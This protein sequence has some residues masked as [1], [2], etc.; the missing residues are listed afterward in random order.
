VQHQKEATTG[1]EIATATRRMVEGVQRTAYEHGM[2]IDPQTGTYFTDCS[3]FVSY[4][5]ESIAPEHY[6][7]IPRE[8][9]H[10][11]PR[12]FEF[13]DYFVSR[14]A[15]PS[16]GWRRVEQ[17]C[18]ARAGDLIAWR[19]AHVEED[20]DSGHVLVIA[21]A[22]IH[23]LGDV[24]GVH[25]YD[26]SAVPHFDDSR[27][28]IGSFAGGVGAGTIIVDVD[29]RGKQVGF[30]FGPDDRFH[31]L[32]IVIARLEPFVLEPGNEN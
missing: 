32:P 1:H 7:A 30:Q 19:K 4:V 20:E 17:L 25:V 18:D 29:A 21:G 6:G 12:A 9:A 23:M 14:A 24:W 22:P 2:I 13:F 11:Y 5:L 28:R 26:S 8:V 15:G 16:L 31:D 3:G 10:A 27:E